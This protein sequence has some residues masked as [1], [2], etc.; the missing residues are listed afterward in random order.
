M[1]GT[2]ITCI[3][4]A[5][6]YHTQIS[7]LR[8]VGIAVVLLAVYIMSVYNKG[9]KGRITLKGV[10]IL[11]CGTLGSALSDFSQKIYVR[12][13]GQGAEIFNFYMYIFGFVMILAFFVGTLL[14]K[15]MPKVSEKLY[16]TKHI[17]IYFAISFFLYINSVMKTMAAGLL[18]AAQ[19]Y[20]VLQG[21]NLIMSALMAHFLFK[22]KMNIKG[23]FG[24]LIAFSGLMIL[25]MAQ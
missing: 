15:K 2:I 22:E 6:I 17:G 18:S 14:N 9:I 11:V 4:D 8:W 23:V 20:P 24:I 16:S 25:H 10:V 13:I 7:F 1:T 3:L 19:I 12:Q 5:V 21:A